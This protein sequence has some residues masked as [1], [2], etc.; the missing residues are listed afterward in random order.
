MFIQGVIS[1]SIMISKSHLP[2]N[3]KEKKL[4]FAITTRQ[5]ASFCYNSHG[6]MFPPRSIRALLPHPNP[7]EPDIP[8]AME[9]KRDLI[10][11]DSEDLF[12]AANPSIPNWKR[13]GRR[14]RFD[15][16]C[17]DEFLKNLGLGT[18]AM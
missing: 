15:W 16:T 2:F 3:Q 13:P 14:A 10:D 11:N 6:T 12:A 8:G 18:V 9:Q 7:S 1:F 5:S 4:T 17:S